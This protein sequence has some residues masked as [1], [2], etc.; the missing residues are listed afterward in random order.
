MLLMKCEPAIH[1]L[2]FHFDLD[3]FDAATGRALFRRQ[4]NALHARR[5][6]HRAAFFLH[7]VGDGLPHHAG[8]EPRIIE[9]IDERAQDA[10]LVARSMSMRRP[11]VFHGGQKRQTLDALRRPLRRD[12]AARHAPDLLGVRLEEGPI[13]ALAEAIFDPLLE[14]ELGFLRCELRF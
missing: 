13:Q 14:G 5:E 9:G 11:G 1:S 3:G 4:A 8:A 7:L 12:L 10:R 6:P 2:T